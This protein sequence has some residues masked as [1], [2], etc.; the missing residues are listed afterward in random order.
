MAKV[1]VQGIEVDVP[2]GMKLEIS[3]TGG[4]SVVAATAEAA[5]PQ[6]QPEVEAVGLPEIG[7]LN[8]NVPVEALQEQQVVEPVAQQETPP[9]LFVTD[10]AERAEATENCVHVTSIADAVAA[11]RRT[12]FS[13]ILVAPEFND[14]ERAIELIQAISEAGINNGQGLT[15]GL[16]TNDPM[17]A[18]A[19]NEE[20]LAVM[21]QNM[22]R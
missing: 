3:P 21:M 19:F 17:E 14:G 12:R 20:G 1:T 6:P 16:D 15:V 8:L 13:C 11:M 5:A 9:R 7:N 4:V 18:M 10:D 2:E 22:H